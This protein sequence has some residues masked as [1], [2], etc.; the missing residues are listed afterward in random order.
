MQAPGKEKSNINIPFPVFAAKSLQLL[1]KIEFKNAIKL[2]VLLPP[3]LH[4]NGD[5]LNIIKSPFCPWSAPV[6]GLN[7][8]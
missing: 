5:L 8:K 4:S 3:T 6:L 7:C 1:Y 2:E